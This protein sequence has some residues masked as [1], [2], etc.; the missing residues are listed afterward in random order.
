MDLLRLGLIT[1]L[2]VGLVAPVL[3]ELAGGTEP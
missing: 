3:A 1:A 2:T